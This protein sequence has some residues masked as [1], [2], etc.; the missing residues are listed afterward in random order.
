MTSSRMRYLCLLTDSEIA[1]SFCLRYWARSSEGDWSERFD[2]L[3]SD[4][5]LS[6]REMLDMLKS[7]CRFYF[8]RVRCSRCEL[9]VSVSTRSEY[10]A[11]I[12]MINRAEREP[13]SLLCTSCAALA[14]APNQISNYHLPKRPHDHVTNALMR[15][16]EKARPIDYEKLGFFQSCLLYAALLA[17]NLAPGRNVLP[18]LEIQI[19]D[20]APTPEL[21][22]E[23]YAQLCTDGILLP[24]LSSDLTRFSL[25]QNTG[26]VTVNIRK[27]AWTLANDVCGRSIE[28]I[29]ELLF[30]KLNQ[31][32]PEATYALWYLVAEDECKR[33]FV[34]QWER[35]RFAH[36][37]IYSAKI[38]AML[39]VYLD[40]FSIGQMWN[41]IHYAVKNLAALTQEG[42]HTP[43][44]IYNMLPGGIRRNA[45]YRL[46]NGQLIRPWHRPSPTSASW[47]T[48]ILLDKILKAGDICFERLRGQDVF[49]YAEYLATQP[50][51]CAA[52][53][54][55]SPPPSSDTRP[56]RD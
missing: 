54:W 7:A 52:A 38:S 49:K 37:G 8:P 15:L 16:H 27:G 22:D 10:S 35:Y 29:L 33:Y 11:L 50:S 41:V 17:A 1:N 3:L 34:S 51:D 14:F 12:G 39:Q 6:K 31:P 9:Q 28:E 5:G 20:L 36:P 13:Y 47:M 4:S 24:A 30:R 45:D 55:F 21:A 2:T 26:A 42:E 43:L 19:E 40:Q 32:D 46:A 53:A 25:E 48:N 18:P 44:H 23:I 56:E